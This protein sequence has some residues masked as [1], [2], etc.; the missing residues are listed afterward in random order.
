[1]KHGQR[2]LAAGMMIVGLWLAAAPAEEPQTQP[3]TA[4][5]SALTS[6]YDAPPSGMHASRWPGA[7]EMPTTAPT[8]SEQSEKDVLEFLQKHMTY[9]YDRLNQLKQS[10][11]T[12]YHRWLEYLE[13][14]VKQLRAMP[15]A[16]RDAHIRNANVRVDILR[17]ARGYHEAKTD[18]ERNALKEGLQTFLSEKF[19]I[20]QKV[21]EYRLQQ[22]DEK[23]QQRKTKLQERAKDREKILA[24]EL[25]C[26][27]Q[28]PAEPGGETEP[29]SPEITPATTPA[30]QPAEPAPAPATETQSAAPET[31]PAEA[32]A[33]ATEPASPET[34]PTTAPAT[35]PE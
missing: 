27:L 5:D 6:E 25:R 13:G 24:E 4:G 7:I 29:A 3:A 12:S 15:E 33:P 34:T 20:E 30:T 11:E 10:D 23:L 19:D 31:A 16:V 14:K 22:L 18:D 9:Y 2:L 26:W 32:P 1:M 28:P 35:Q 21:G 17:T 8:V